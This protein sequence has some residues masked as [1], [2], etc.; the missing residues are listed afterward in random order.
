M[1]F[2]VFK[3]QSLPTSNE[4]ELLDAITRDVNSGIQPEDIQIDMKHR[5]RR[6][7]S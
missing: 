3:K 4:A 7:K 1:L 6:S 5:V 2:K